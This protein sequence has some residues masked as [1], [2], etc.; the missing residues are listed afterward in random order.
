VPSSDVAATLRL[1]E[2]RGETLATAESLTAGLVSAT[3]ADVPGAS[4]VLRGGLA[5]YASDVKVDVLGVA[6]GIVQVHG[7]VSAECAEAMAAGANR[8]FGTDWA[9]STTGV[10]GPT[11]QEGKPVGTVF[12]AVAH[13]ERVRSRELRLA[14]DR[15]TIRGGATAAVLELLAAELGDA[16]ADG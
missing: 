13:R 5:A 10:A 3:I 12:V 9:V 16:E 8:L 2:E 11:E 15:A 6:P 4:A 1:L 14:G 7:V